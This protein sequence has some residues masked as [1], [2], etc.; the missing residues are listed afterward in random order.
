MAEFKF[1]CSRCGQSIQ[2]DVDYGSRQINCPACGQST[3]VPPTANSP[4]TT[5]AGKAP[6]WARRKTLLI[7]AAVVVLLLLFAGAGHFLYF[8]LRGKPGG[9]VAWWRADGNA[10]DSAGH[11]DGLLQGG[12]HFAPGEFGQAFLFDSP[13][14]AVKIAANPSLNV[15]T[16]SGFTIE[17]WVEPSS[18]SHLNPL[19][20]WNTGRGSWGVHFYIG[21]GAPDNLYANIVDSGHHWHTI[22]TQGGIV[23][24]NG[25]QHIALTYNKANGVAKIYYNGAAV[26]EQPVGKFKPQTTYDV[27]LGRRPPTGGESY[28]FAGLMDEV[29]IYHRALSSSEIAAIYSAG[30][31]K[32]GD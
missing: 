2:A 3:I 21:V 23:R 9:L 10:R 5:P 27:Y 28:T 16:D 30:K 14:D 26:L 25:F 32:T 12:M 29:S 18:L 1:F 15:G 8:E 6:S 13:D 19:V 11:N 24:T 17:C 4:A 31:S 20:E 7:A 22:Q